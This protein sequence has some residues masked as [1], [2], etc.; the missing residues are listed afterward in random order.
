[1]KPFKKRDYP[2]SEIRR[3]LEPGPIVLVSSAWKGKTNIMTMGWHMMMQFTPALFASYIW[4]GNHSF[5]MI[6]RSKECVINVP[7]TDLVN[8]VVE[9]GNCSGEEI[10]K[11]KTFGLTPVP[12]TKVDV[13]LIKECYA[14]FE[15]KL[16]DGRLISKY[17]VF[18][19]EVIKAHVATSP[20]HPETLHY[21]GEGVFMISGR[22]INLRKKFKS[23]NL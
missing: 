15:C 23:Q 2:L 12:G 13:P 11:F 3:H 22:S 5:E 19:W 7:T 10:D 9:I 8:E 17:G 14:N 1:M 16:A 6:R 20:K 4:D 18:I 21:R